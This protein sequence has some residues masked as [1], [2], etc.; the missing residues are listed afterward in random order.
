[1]SSMPSK[2]EQFS[3]SDEIMSKML[4]ESRS[5]A[6]VGISDKLGRP[7]L[8]VS[9][10]LQDHGYQVY[11]VN[12]TLESVGH[13]KCHPSLESLPV[14]PD[15]CVVFR[16]ASDIPDV[17]KEA[18]RKGISRIWVQEG[19]Q[20]PEGYRIAKDMGLEIVMDRCIMKE[21]MRIGKSSI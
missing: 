18:H 20:S 11:P 17:I 19:I 7:S 2:I 13:V 5:V 12:P 16:K 10:Y 4:S 3:V 8:T 15:L 9:S 6:V 14:T 1:M 21:Y